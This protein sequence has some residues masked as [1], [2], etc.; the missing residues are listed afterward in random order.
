MNDVSDQLAELEATVAY[1]K[2]GRN[3][4]D[5]DLDALTSRYVTAAEVATAVP[6]PATVRLLDDLGAEFELR[7]LQAPKWVFAVHHIGLAELRQK[8]KAAARKEN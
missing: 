3:Y 8:A 7:G 4:E 2:A 5:L 1:V 6:T